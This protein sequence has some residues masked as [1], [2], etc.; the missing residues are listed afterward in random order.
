[1]ADTQNS[2]GQTP[3]FTA[4]FVDCWK[5]LPN[6]AL[7]FA[8]LAAWF[9]LFQILGNATFGYIN[10]PSLFM[11]MSNAYSKGDRS[12]EHG[13]L[14]PIVVLVL[15]W[16][17]RKQLLAVPIRTWAPALVLLAFAMA[18]HVAGYLVQQ[19][20]ISIVALFVGIYALTGLAWGPAWLRASFFPFFLF[21]FCVPFSSIAEPVT[22]PLRLFVSKVVAGISP[23]L[24]VDVR[25]EGTQLYNALHTY[26]YEVAAACSGLRSVVAVLCISTVYGFITFQE[27]WKRGV[28]ILA[29][30]PLAV[31]SNVIRML[32]IIV[33]AELSTLRPGSR[34]LCPREF[35]LQSASLH[36]CHT[37]RDAHRPLAARTPPAV[38]PHPPGEAGMNRKQVILLVA[39]LAL[40]GGGAV[41][42]G[43]LTTHQR[44]GKPGILT[45]AIPGSPRLN[46]LLPEHVANYQ[47]E[48]VTLDTNLFLYL[49]QD[50]SFAQ[51]RYTG[52]DEFQVLLN[53]V[54]MGADR[55][56]IHKPEFCLAGQGCVIDSA[57]SS[58]VAVPMQLPQPYNLPVKK[59]YTSRRVMF[60]GRVLQRNGIFA[61]WFVAD[62]QLS[63][64]HGGRMLHLAVQLLRTGVVERWAYIA[65]FA[66]CWP[67]Q[68]D[69]TWRRMEAFIQSAAPQ[70]QLVPGQPGTRAALAESSTTPFR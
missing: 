27:Y 14:I 47:S 57:R 29:S 52:P 11:W 8:L 21:A 61:Y 10:T 7:F 28:L 22:F 66:E 25:R 34:Q 69:E 43:W 18:L 37:G 65:C 48:P 26:Q 23:I 44:L 33:A 46:I 5:Q 38:V 50:T 62:N 35:H 31:L 17:K 36:P 40:I 56:S 67:G 20:R 30:V 70:F 16:W 6:K 68:E 2:P 13:F 59:L 9:L 41:A 3:S 19:P 63:A 51:R 15:F 32:C 55:S 64:S 1:M 49:P 54:L 53:V 58:Q 60:E 45:S 42:L 39:G 4:E 24:G 12:D